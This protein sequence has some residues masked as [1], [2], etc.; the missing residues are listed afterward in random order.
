MNEHREKKL[1]DK[2]QLLEAK[3]VELELE[4]TAAKYCPFPSA[5]RVCE[6]VCAC[7]CV[8]VCSLHQ[9]FRLL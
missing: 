4:T 9:F 3:I 1:Q 7:V 6:C 2:I 8:R 5:V